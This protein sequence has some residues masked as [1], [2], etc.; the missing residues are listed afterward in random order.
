MFLLCQL[1][2]RLHKRSGLHVPEGIKEHPNDLQ[3]HPEWA[4][5]KQALSRKASNILKEQLGTIDSPAGVGLPELFL[6]GELA[7]RKAVSRKHKHITRVHLL[8][9]IQI[10]VR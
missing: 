8:G 4:L 2:I 5:S 10:V 3:K 1:L 6:D 9:E 7:P